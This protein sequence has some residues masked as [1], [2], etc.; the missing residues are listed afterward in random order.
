MGCDGRN[1]WGTGSGGT[2]L[3]ET[4]LTD[5]AAS[6][7]IL[8]VGAH[9]EVYA[10]NVFAL[11]TPCCSGHPVPWR[12]VTEGREHPVPVRPIRLPGPHRD[13]AS[14]VWPGPSTP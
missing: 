7:R 11:N 12:A 3:G 4:V 8:T 5:P 10:D 14:A 13:D 6:L 2:R 1:L 9:A